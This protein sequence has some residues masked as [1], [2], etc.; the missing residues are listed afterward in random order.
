LKD[1]ELRGVILEKFYEVR[2]QEPRMVDPLRL[3]G[4]DLIEPDQIRG[5]NICEQLEEHG[6]L[7][8]KSFRGLQ[9]IGGIGHIS[10]TGVDVI[11]GTTPAPIAINLH[12][13]SVNQSSNVQIGDSN[14]QDVSV[15]IETHDLARLVTELTNHLC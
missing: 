11:E 9:S 15:R 5:L 4:L 10:A 7:H 6:L 3:P 2:N 14:V 8:W 12:S 13:I 1:G